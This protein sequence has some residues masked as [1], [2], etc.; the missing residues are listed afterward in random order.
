M[1]KRIEM[2]PKSKIIAKKKPKMSK[3]EKESSPA[4]EPVIELPN[5]RHSID[6]TQA[7]LVS[8]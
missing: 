6:E 8:T 5:I 4:K 7:P 3:E 1:S 2:E